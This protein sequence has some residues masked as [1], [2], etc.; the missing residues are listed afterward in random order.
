[1]KELKIYEFQ[2][3]NIENSLRI[4]SNLLKCKSKETC[5]DREV[6]W[7]W[8]TIKNIINEKPDIFVER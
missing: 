4:V 5:L 6:V 2:A 7:A 1:M 3:K 8:E